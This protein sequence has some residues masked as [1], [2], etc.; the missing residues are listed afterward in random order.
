MVFPISCSFAI[1]PRND[2]K[3]ISS[4]IVKTFSAAIPVSAVT[5][6]LDGTWQAEAVPEA[7]GEAIPTAFTRTI[8]VPGHWP[9]FFH[10]ST[11]RH[12]QNVL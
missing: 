2:K 1:R 10:D 12:N 11:A 6:S 4:T 9:R 5:I 3:N 7:L 8:P